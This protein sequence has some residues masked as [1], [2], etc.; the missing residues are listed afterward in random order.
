MTFKGSETHF[1]D[2]EF[3]NTW[4]FYFFSAFQVPI[5]PSKNNT[6]LLTQ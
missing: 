6:I 2:N 3:A 4:L 1:D 5:R